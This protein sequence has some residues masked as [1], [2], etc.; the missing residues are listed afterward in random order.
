MA[1]DVIFTEDAYVTRAQHILPASCL[2]MP[3]AIV[4]GEVSKATPSF[5]FP[6]GNVIV[7]GFF[8]GGGCAARRAA[9]A[10]QTLS[11]CAV[12]AGFGS[13]VNAPPM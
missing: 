13:G 7:M 12:K 9:A 4:N 10:S 6:S 11:R 1:T 2:E 8:C 3:N 5:V